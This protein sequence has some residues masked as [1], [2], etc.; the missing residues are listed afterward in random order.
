IWLRDE[1]GYI[2]YFA[3]DV[4]T[5]ALVQR[6]DDVDTT[7]VSGAPAGWN[8][9]AGGGLHLVNDYQF[10]A[11]GRTVQEIGPGH[12]IDVSGIAT[13][14]RS[15]AWTVYDDVNTTVRVGRGYATGTA[16]NYAYTL[17]NPVAITV[18]DLNQNVVQEIQATRASTSGALLSSDTFAQSS[19]VR[20]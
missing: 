15:A 11:F 20:W 3:Y 12:T 13:V 18:Y 19:Y 17:V 10:D 5:G 9:P 8:T 2:T 7:Q 1:R 14:V 6:I 16:P 4:A